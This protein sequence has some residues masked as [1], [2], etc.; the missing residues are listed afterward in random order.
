MAKRISYT[1]ELNK[2]SLKKKL[3]QKKVLPFS[4]PAYL[5]VSTLLNA[6]LKHIFLKRLLVRLLIH[7]I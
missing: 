4:N 7:L 3:H 2:M 1:Y 5:R 6:L